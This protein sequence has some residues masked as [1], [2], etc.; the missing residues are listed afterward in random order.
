MW[1][2]MVVLEKPASLITLLTLGSSRIDIMSCSNSTLIVKRG[3]CCCCSTQPLL[4]WACALLRAAISALEREGW[5]WSRGPGV[6]GSLLRATLKQSSRALHWSECDAWWCGWWGWW[7]LRQ[8][9]LKRLVLE[10]NKVAATWRG[11]TCAWPLLL[12]KPR[13]CFNTEAAS[14][15]RVCW[16]AQAPERIT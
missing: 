10:L 5:P 4:W 11:V 8:A 3:C 14:V 15:V 12:A 1:F 9:L 6:V 7:D 13:E 16:T 2:L